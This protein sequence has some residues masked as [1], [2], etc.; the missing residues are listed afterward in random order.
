MVVEEVILLDN[1]YLHYGKQYLEDCYIEES[2]DFIF[3]NN[4]PLL[5][6]CHIHYKSS[7]YI[8]AQSKKYSQETIG[9]VFLI[10]DELIGEDILQSGS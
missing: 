10:S 9:Y 4:T 2:V 3:G 1:L 5:E 7:E 8:T 6:H